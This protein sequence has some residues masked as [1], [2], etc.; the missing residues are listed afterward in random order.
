MDTV[1]TLFDD[2]VGVASVVAVVVAVVASVAS[3][4]K[5]HRGLLI[6]A[7]VASAELIVLLTLVNRGFESTGTDIW[8]ELTWW[9]LD[10]NL[11]R[12]S[13]YVGLL[14]NIALFAPAGFTYTLLTRRPLL[15]VGALVI[16]SFSIETLQATVLTGQPDH[17]DVLANF[18][19]A[20]TG[21]VA[22]ALLKRAPRFS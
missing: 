17:F 5:G 1:L 8:T 10:V 7:A 13:D 21:V 4:R 2:R 3:Q 6:G 15:V 9:R 12:G 20:A 18:L 14:F 16:V 19:G 11:P 22:A